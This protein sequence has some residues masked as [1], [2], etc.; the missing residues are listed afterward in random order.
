[1]SDTKGSLVPRMFIGGVADGKWQDV[2]ESET[3]WH[4]QAVI[5]TDPYV[6]E[7]LKYRDPVDFR[8][9]RTMYRLETFAF[10]EDRRDDI[11]VFVAQNMT[12]RDAFRRMMTRYHPSKPA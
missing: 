11:R 7:L 12:A 6:C 1:M 5:L 4:R 3:Y 2:P 8:S 10:G 9:E